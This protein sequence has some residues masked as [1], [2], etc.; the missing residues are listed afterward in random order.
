MLWLLAC[1]N[2]PPVAADESPPDILLVVLDTVRADR[3]ATYGYAR[4]TSYQLNAIAEAGVVFEDV[5][6]S[7]P[8]TWPGHAAL[9]TGEPPWVTG[10]H[11]VDTDSTVPVQQMRTDLP[12]LAEGLSDAGYRTVSVAG[13]NLLEESLGLVRGFSSAALLHDD[14]ETVQAATEAMNADDDRPLFL[15][16]NLVSAH[17]P[18]FLVDGV[19]F[20]DAHRGRVMAGDGATLSAMRV[21]VEGAVGI[22][23]GQHCEGFR[24]DLKWTAGDWDI[25]D[26]DL[27]LIGDLYDSN[28]V[29]VDNALKALIAAWTAEHGGVVV[30]TSDHGEALGEHRMLQHRLMTIPSIINVPLV[31]VGP[32]FPAGTRSDVPVQLRDLY[33][34]L[35]RLAGAQD[36]AGWDLRDGAIGQARPGSIESAA[37]P[38]PRTAMV[39]LVSERWSYLREGEVAV[40]VSGERVIQLGNESADAIFRERA[41]AVG[42]DAPRGELLGSEHIARLQA[43]GYLQ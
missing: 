40:A 39:P 42:S 41:R 18:Y 16:V 34:T 22:D 3:L 25:S 9:F 33:P 23:P 12:T 28:L 37:W 5:T 31:A 4:D 35:L 27:D 1:M 7:G 32:G 24:C 38:D 15:F 8:W 20:S 36:D 14:A 11:Y 43:L 17:A 26:A 13:N 10:A 6:V 19:P 21:E 2:E 29:Q 30:V